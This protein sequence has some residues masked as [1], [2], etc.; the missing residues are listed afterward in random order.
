V[1]G[2]GTEPVTANND[3]MYR[4]LEELVGLIKEI[5]DSLSSVDLM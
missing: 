2:Y 4:H 5:I 1:R 3:V